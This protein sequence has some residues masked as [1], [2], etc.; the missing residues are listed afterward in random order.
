M[1]TKTYDI[2]IESLMNDFAFES[3][4]IFMNQSLQSFIK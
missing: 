3:F 4:L 2:Y 1:K